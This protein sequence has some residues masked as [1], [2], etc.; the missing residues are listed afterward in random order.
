MTMTTNSF[1]SIEELDSTQVNC[2]DVTRQVL[3]CNV[4]ICTN[5]HIGSDNC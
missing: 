2:D 3:S 4:A 1:V 5:K